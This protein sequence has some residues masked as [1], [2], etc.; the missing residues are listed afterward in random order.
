MKVQQPREENAS[1][2]M[3]EEEESDDDEEIMI[4]KLPNGLYNLVIG[5][6]IK[7]EIRKEWWESLIVKLLER[8]ISLIAMKRRLEILWGKR[9]SIEVIDLGCEFFLV[10]FF[11][12]EDWTLPL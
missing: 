1:I 6:S 2:S 4:E 5:E 7:C 9:G 10:R 12:S 3:E 8:K 11:N